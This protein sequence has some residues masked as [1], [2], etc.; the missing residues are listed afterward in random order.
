MTPDAVEHMLARLPRS[1]DLQEV[2]R[3]LE[4]AG[5]VLDALEEAYSE[6]V[7]TWLPRRRAM[8]SRSI[9]QAF[10]AVN[11]AI[12]ALVIDHD[13]EGAVERLT[14]AVP[15]MRRAWVVQMLKVV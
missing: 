3:V 7:S 14:D 10:E 4:H 1:P 6:H 9:H 11:H 12:L 8:A 2:D 5:S 13:V 15:A